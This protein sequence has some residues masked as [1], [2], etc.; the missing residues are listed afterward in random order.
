MDSKNLIDSFGNLEKQLRVN[1]PIFFAFSSD[2]LCKL[3][4][5]SFPLFSYM[6]HDETQA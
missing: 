1:P 5:K 4:K 2:F 3:K 6:I